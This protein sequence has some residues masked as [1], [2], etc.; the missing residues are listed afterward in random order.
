[1]C[2]VTFIPNRNGYRI[3]MNRDERT[4]RPVASL[5]AVYEQGSIESIYPRDFEGGTWIGVNSVGNAF[6][7]LNW[8]DT[9]ALEA[10]V[11][12]RGSAVPA[13]IGSADSHVAQSTLFSLN[14]R[15]ILPFTL[16][17]FFPQEEELLVWRWNQRSLQS[18]FVSWQMRQWCSSSLS[19]SQ[20]SV[21]RGE[22]LA[23][24]LRTRDTDSREWFRKLHGSHLPGD[25]AFSI[26]VHRGDVETV[27]YTELTCTDRHVECEYVGGSPCQVGATAHSVMMPRTTVLAG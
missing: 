24:A 4:V 8:N 11:H 16:L 6:A 5:P 15:G 14:L 18:E 13:I 27:S 9:E 7:L 26:C 12:S 22:V 3:G 23:L 20:A 19:D 17:G 10:K 21:R 2:T 25:P 1:M